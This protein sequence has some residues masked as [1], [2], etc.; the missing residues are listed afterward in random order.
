MSKGPDA[1]RTISEVAEDLDLPQHVLR[2]WETR[3]TQIRPMKRGGGRRYYRPDDVELL[4]GI[5]RLLYGEGYTIKGVQRILKEHGPRHVVAAGQ[6]LALDPTPS[7]ADMGVEFGDE[8]PDG[9]LVDDDWDMG[10][11]DE[12]AEL[13]RVSLHRGKS[14]ES[15]RRE[16]VFGSQ[17]AARPQAPTVLVRSPGDRQADIRGRD[18]APPIP[19]VSRIPVAPPEEPDDVEVYL[20]PVMDPSPYAPDR[21]PSESPHG[22]Q[23]PHGAERRDPPQPARAA[24]PSFPAEAQQVEPKRAATPPRFLPLEPESAEDA[25]GEVSSLSHDEIRQLKSTLFELLECK[26]LLDQS[27]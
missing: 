13:P 10:R 20:P 11:P 18:V 6:G 3:F 21:R 25:S 16:P 19:S 17:A 9:V 15:T 26:R 24:S 23:A 4:R 8:I 1:F 7:N 27:R 22:F 2:F 12:P 14:E 5:R